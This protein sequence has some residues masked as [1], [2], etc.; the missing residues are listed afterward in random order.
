MEDRPYLS[1][2]KDRHGK[3]RWRFRRGK[4]NKSLPGEPGDPRFEASYD[5][6]L[7]GRP[8]PAKI[9]RH[10]N[11]AKPR[12]LKAA[13]RLATASNNMDWQKLGQ[14]SR[15]SYIERAERLLG[16]ELAPGLTYAD[17]PVADLKRRHVKAML[18]AL[19]GT[20][21]AA[22]DALVVLR[23]MILVALDEEWIEVDPTHRLKYRPESD[24]HRAWTDDERAKYE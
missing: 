15:G 8:L 18:G 21:H 3:R 5:D 16:M 12:T 14:S 1:S 17:A 4:V 2:Y 7:N 19:S 10:P 9:I 22:Y 23:K 24:G 20:P 6:L 11:Q 13:W